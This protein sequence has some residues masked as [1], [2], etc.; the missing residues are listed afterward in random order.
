MQLLG[1]PKVTDIEDLLD[2]FKDYDA[3]WYIGESKAHV[4]KA[5]MQRAGNLALSPPLHTH[6]IA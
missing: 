6:D 4:M 3:N 1:D 2:T 5:A